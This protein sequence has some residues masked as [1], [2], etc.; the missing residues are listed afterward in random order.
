MRKD[1]IGETEKESRKSEKCERGEKQ[2]GGREG[3]R[4]RQ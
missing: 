4:P 1:D 3:D 2:R